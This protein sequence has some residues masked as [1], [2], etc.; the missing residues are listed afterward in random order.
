MSD[1]HQP[2]HRRS[3]RTIGAALLALACGL[4]TTVPGA[5][6]RRMP[7]VG[8]V[9]T[10]VSSLPEELQDVGF[11]QRLGEDVPLQLEVRDEL[12]NTVQLGSLF[13]GKPVILV[14]AYYECP[15]LC[16]MVINDLTSALRVV[17]LKPG[18]DFEVVI[19]SIDPDETPKMALTAKNTAVGRYDGGDGAGWHFLTASQE[20]IDQLSEA[21]GFHYYY[22][23][24][25]DEFA[26]T[27]GILVLTP[28]GKIARYFFGLEYPPRELR[29]AMVE[30][31]D[32]KI[33][34][35]ADKLL[36]FCFQWNPSTGRYSAVTL[37]IVRLGGAVTLLGVLLMVAWLI[38]RERRQN[39]PSLGT[40]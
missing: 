26:H 23:E 24:K 2:T 3:R 25:S 7:A 39:K 18:A 29:L 22:D 5:A 33:G 17:P 1:F 21:I 35:M 9:D 13:A 36:L 11:D 37:N 34:S 40:T 20:S 31:A 16:T 14:P 10:D 38:W 6:Q 4:A 19:Y 8:S 12:G 30:A 27:A 28:A 15:M 32:E